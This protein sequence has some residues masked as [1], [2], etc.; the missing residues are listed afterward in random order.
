MKREFVRDFVQEGG[1]YDGRYGSNEMYTLV[2]EATV[3]ETEVSQD[4]P[5]LRHAT[6]EVDENENI[7]EEEAPSISHR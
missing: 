7:D 4:F 1:T 3:Y 2:E 5:D 6:Y